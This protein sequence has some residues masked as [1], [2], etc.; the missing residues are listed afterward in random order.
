[1]KIFLTRKIFLSAICGAVLCWGGCSPTLQPEATVV[2]GSRIVNDSYIGNGAQWDPYSLHFSDGVRQISSEDS[3]KIARRLDYM[4]P[5]FIRVM[6]NTSRPGQEG[7][8]PARQFGKDL[9]MI[10]N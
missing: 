7:Y 6:S 2:I 4:R 9:E 8:D 10:L 3:A 5:Q 1:M